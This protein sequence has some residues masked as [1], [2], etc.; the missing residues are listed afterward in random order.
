MAFYKRR[1]A[2]T[3]YL[4]KKRGLTIDA[5]SPVLLGKRMVFPVLARLEKAATY[6]SATAKEAALL[7]LVACR[8]GKFHM[9]FMKGSDLSMQLIILCQ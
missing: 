6:C 2:L 3:D 9:E 1:Y 5:T 4:D 7:P 8:M